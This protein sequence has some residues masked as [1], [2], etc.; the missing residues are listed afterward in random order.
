[1]QDLSAAKKAVIDREIFTLLEKGLASNLMSFVAKLLGPEGL[2]QKTPS[3]AA[4]AAQAQ[5]RLAENEDNQDQKRWEEEGAREITGR[6]GRVR[7]CTRAEQNP[8]CTP[9]PLHVCVCVCQ[10]HVHT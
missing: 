6:E 1:M 7:G 3:P 8:T 9:R 4:T 10:S 2:R 5:V